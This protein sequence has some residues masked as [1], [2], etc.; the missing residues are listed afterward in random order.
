MT[1]AQSSLP[2]APTLPCPVEPCTVKAQLDAPRRKMAQLAVGIGH[3]WGRLPTFK[4]LSEVHGRVR[5]F[6]PSLAEY[7]K[8]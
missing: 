2:H 1:G 6:D 4:R 5:G 7:G 3:F 8:N